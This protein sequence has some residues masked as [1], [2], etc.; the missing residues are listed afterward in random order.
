MVYS[1]SILIC[2]Y[3]GSKRKRIIAWTRKVNIENAWNSFFFKLQIVWTFQDGFS[4][5]I[6]KYIFSTSLSD[7]TRIN[8]YIF[9]TSLSDLTRINK[10][11]FSISLSDLTRINKYIFFGNIA[12]LEDNSIDFV[13]SLIICF[14][15]VNVN[16][17][18]FILFYV[19]CDI[20]FVLFFFVPCLVYPELPVSLDC[21]FLLLL[22]LR[23]SLK[24]IYLLIKLSWSS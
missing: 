10:Y 12:Y 21:P 20:L 6:N 17:M 4:P 15:C 19:L 8:K 16:W 7:L 2:N 24:F 18:R 13:K 1:Y 5:R 11:I 9:S 14:D 23:F 3:T 22:P